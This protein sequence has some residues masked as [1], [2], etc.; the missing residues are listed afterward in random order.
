MLETFDVL[1]YLRN[2]RIP[3]WAEGKNVTAGWVELQCLWC[4]DRSHHL[5]VNLDTRFMSCWR[6]GPK[7]PFSNY[8]MTKENYNYRQAR[9]V[10]NEFQQTVY[11]SLRQDIQI[12]NTDWDRNILPKEATGD[13]PES[14]L[15]YLRGRR[16]DPV[17][18]ITQYHLKAIG[19]WCTTSDNLCYRILIPVLYEGRV[20]NYTARDVTGRAETP[21]VNC[22]NDQAIIPIRDCIYNRDSVRDTVLIVEGPIDV[23]RMGSGSISVF[24]M[25]VS[26]EQIGAIVDTGAKRAFVMFDGEEQA[27]KKAHKVAMALSGLIPFV[28]VLELEKGD[29]D[30]L[31]EKDVQEIRKLV[32][33]Y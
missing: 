13:F 18:L 9:N 12:R 6:C 29:P 24:G 17:K 21:Y 32:F 25:E 3:Y 27:I 4:N 10:L 19:N 1:A 5:G 11:R 26:K 30:S 33:G 20:V 14:Y 16:Y 31:E 15:N 22:K 7:G 2:R 8:I 23:W 28:E